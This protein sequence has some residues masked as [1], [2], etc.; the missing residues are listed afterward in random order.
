MVNVIPQPMDSELGVGKLGIDTPETDWYIVYQG[1]DDDD[2]PDYNAATGLL[3]DLTLGA[4]DPPGDYYHYYKFDADHIHCLSLHDYDPERHYPAIVLGHVDGS[5]PNPPTLIQELMW[6]RD[7][8][9]TTVVGLGEEGYV[10]DVPSLAT[11][12][13]LILSSTAK[14]RYYGTQTLLQLISFATSQSDPFTAFFPECH[15]EDKP[16]MPTRAVHI[17]Y[18]VNYKAGVQSSYTLRE[19]CQY[20]ASKLLPRGLDDTRSPL[21]VYVKLL[22]RM[23]I[24][25]LVIDSPVFYC[26]DADSGYDDKTNFELIE[27]LIKCCRKWHIE[28]VPMLQS[29]GWAKYV[30]QFLPNQVEACWVGSSDWLFDP[31]LIPLPQDC[32]TFYS[33]NHVFNHTFVLNDEDERP[34]QAWWSATGNSVDWHLLDPDEDYQLEYL[35]VDFDLVHGFTCGSLAAEANRNC[36]IHIDG[37]KHQTAT[38]FKVSYH[39]VNQSFGGEPN[40]EKR[41]SYCPTSPKV[42]EFMQAT[43]DRVVDKVRPRYLHL[44]HDEPWQMFTCAS[45]RGAIELGQEEHANG[46]LFANEVNTLLGYYLDACET[47]GVQNPRMIIYGDRVNSPERNYHHPYFHETTNPLFH[48]EWWYGGMGGAVDE[49]KALLNTSIIINDWNYDIET[50]EEMEDWVRYQVIEELTDLGFD[51]IGGSAGYPKYHPVDYETLH[52]GALVKVTIWKSQDPGD[53]KTYFYYCD[54]EGTYQEKLGLNTGS[55]TFNGLEWFTR[56]S[57]GYYYDKVEEGKIYDRVSFKCDITGIDVEGK[58]WFEDVEFW[59]YNTNLQIWLP[60][61]GPNTNPD[62]DYSFETPGTQDTFDKWTDPDDPEDT[63]VFPDDSDKNNWRCQL[64]DGELW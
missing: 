59:W 17:A 48:D 42:K 29:F 57:E 49:C 54:L 24:N 4:I 18:P 46:I 55:Q 22:S 5:M 8:E 37:S 32:E 7:I 47:Y 6:A 27:P 52:C 36:T 19:K 56:K 15:I 28:P 2:N 41:N 51:V 21:E 60:I 35:P 1:Q 53:N 38:V 45:C 23:K 40:T 39:F 50:A 16:E 62:T 61:V 26:L 34:I 10:L 58:A 14:G 11:D 25:M 31:S 9:D 44:G 3:E 30:L 64:S 13:I 12:P 43:I 63:E 33:L 20:E